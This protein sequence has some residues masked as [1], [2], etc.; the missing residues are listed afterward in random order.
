D[1]VFVD[2]PGLRATR[3]V[4]LPGQ[5]ERR[6]PA[7]VVSGPEH[8]TVVRSRRVRHFDRAVA[9]DVHD[10]IE[11]IGGGRILRRW[12]VDGQVGGLRAGARA[13]RGFPPAAG[14]MD[15]EVHARRCGDAE[16]GCLP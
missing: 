14:T 11:V 2:L 12:N 7:V 16:E 9:G 10:R 3:E 13:G 1:P 6:V 15:L 5:V 4:K 8:T